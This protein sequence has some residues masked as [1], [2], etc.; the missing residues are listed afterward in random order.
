MSFCFL[1]RANKNHR[2]TSQHPLWWMRRIGAALQLPPCCFGG[3]QGRNLV[4]VK[5]LRNL[6]NRQ[7][8]VVFLRVQYSVRFFD[9][10]CLF[11]EMINIKKRPSS[12][13]SFIVFE[14]WYVPLDCD[15]YHLLSSGVWICVWFYKNHG[16]MAQ[17]MPGNCRD[18]PDLPD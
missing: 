10:F 14:A 17:V 8:E 5:H 13:G 2:L 11:I 3:C 15:D 4:I 12:N 16:E 1:F 9:V 7:K 18:S 6:P